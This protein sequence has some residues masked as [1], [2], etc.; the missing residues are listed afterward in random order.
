MTRLGL[1]NSHVQELVTPSVFES[2]TFGLRGRKWAS[3]P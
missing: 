1:F 3:L 2:N